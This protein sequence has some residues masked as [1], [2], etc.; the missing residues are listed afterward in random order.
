MGHAG[1]LRLR[2]VRARGELAGLDALMHGRARCARDWWLVCRR[3]RLLP[4]ER[5]HAGLRCGLHPGR[6]RRDA[7]R[8]RRQLRG[9]R[10][11]QCRHRQVQ[12]PWVRLVLLLSVSA[13]R[14][15]ALLR[16]E[17]LLLVRRRE[18]R[19]PVMLRRV[20]RVS[21]RLRLRREQSRR[22]LLVSGWHVSLG[23]PR[24]IVGGSRR[25]EDRWRARSRLGRRPEGDT[26][27]RRRRRG[28][29]RGGRRAHHWG[30]G[31]M[32]RVQATGRPG[33]EDGSHA[34]VGRTTS[35]RVHSGR[36]WTSNTWKLAQ[37]EQGSRRGSGATTRQGEPG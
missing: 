25:Q 36:A 16:W 19:R 35:H 13:R 17:W 3:Y 33:R 37:R 26:R 22:L 27:R 24:R 20:R 29:G 34:N 6:R 2:L 23:W 12:C 15:R 28:R 18:G 8:A 5:V 30:D 11:L 31:C 10:R 9:R 14:H 7:G 1:L 32:H 4:R 21:H